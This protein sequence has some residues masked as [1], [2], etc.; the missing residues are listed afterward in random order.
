[1]PISKKQLE[2][3]IRLTSL[4]K[5]NRYPNCS[6]FASEMRKADL[7]E[8]LN[9][10]CTAK[11]IYRDIQILKNDFNAPIK[12]DFKRNGYYLTHHNWSFSCPKIF[13]D[14][15][16]LSAVLGARVAEYIFPDPLKSNIRKCVD[17][18]LIRNNP[19]FLDKTQMNSLVVIPG[20]R[21]AVNADIFLPLYCAWQNHEV[22]RIL[23][24]DS[25]GRL[26]E[27]D[28]EPHVLVFFDGVWY[29]KG[30]CR[31]RNG[32][33]T[34]AVPRM[35]SVVSTQETSHPA[36]Q[37]IDSVNEE[38]LFDPELVSNVA[39]AC[40]AY[41]ANIIQTRPLHAD[42]EI[43]HCSQDGCILK[44]GKMSKYRLITWIMHQCGRATVITPHSV[45]DEIAF[46][47]ERLSS[48]HAV[49]KK[50]KCKEE[51]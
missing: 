16:M 24:R 37:I 25:K 7:D 46:F 17:Y 10:A 45:R 35:E 12:F 47:A 32:T 6:T 49:S 30:F 18:L 34:L 31:T 29:T 26:S 14:T 27:R 3:L 9:L 19:N 39:V 23:Y 1:M 36:P 40:D 8:N 21:T 15:E 43:C 13:D 38:G 48:N 20:N 44:V 28:F 33:R 22:C 41:L 51:Q 5:E 42:Q 11:T 50:R 4:L 2:R